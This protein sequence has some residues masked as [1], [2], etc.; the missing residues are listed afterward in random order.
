[1]WQALLTLV[2][3]KKYCTP[4]HRAHQVAG[5]GLQCYTHDAAKEH[6]VLS[7]VQHMALDRAPGLGASVVKTPIMHRAGEDS[8]LL[9]LL[10]S[11]YKL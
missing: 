6:R 8:T 5:L 3:Q 2:W 9:M 1:M 4:V 7:T 10:P 11:T